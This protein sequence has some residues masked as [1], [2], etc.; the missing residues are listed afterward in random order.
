MGKFHGIWNEQCEAV[1]ERSAGH[2]A[3]DDA[4]EALREA[5]RRHE[6][7]VTDIHGRFAR[8]GG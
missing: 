1:P 2:G 3:C 4:N 5:G 6:L 8:Q 7:S